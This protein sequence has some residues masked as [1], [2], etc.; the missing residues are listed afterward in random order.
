MGFYTTQRGVIQ[1]FETVIQEQVYNPIYNMDERT[2]KLIIP[3]NTLHRREGISPIE[4]WHLLVFDINQCKWQSYNSCREGSIGEQCLK[5]CKIIAR[6]CKGRI[7]NWLEANHREVRLNNW[8]VEV[9]RV[10][11]QRTPDSLLFMC[12]WIKRCCKRINLLEPPDLYVQKFLQQK[13]IDLAY[14]LLTASNP[15]SSWGVDTNFE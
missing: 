11:Q 6:R 3:M 7:N 15:E 13:K 8:S 2:E 1:N 9:Q 5:E 14:K 12:N 4:Q 10:S